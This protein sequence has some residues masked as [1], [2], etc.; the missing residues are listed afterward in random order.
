MLS[1]TKKFALLTTG[2]VGAL[3][4][5]SAVGVA[6]S[7][8][9]T[10]TNN[11][12][13]TDENTKYNTY[14][15]W[16]DPSALD[17]L[18]VDEYGF[19]YSD[20]YKHTI[21]A[22]TPTFTATTITIPST[23]TSITGYTEVLPSGAT[24]TR[25]AFQPTA[26]YTPS[27]SSASGTDTEYGVTLAN[28]ITTVKFAAGSKLNAIG[29]N[30]FNGCSLLQSIDLPSTVTMIGSYAFNGCSLL[31]T[32]NLENV[33]F[34]G[35][36]AF[37]SVGSN[38][39]NPTISVTMNK[40]TVV[41]QY[42]F[43]NSK[44]TSLNLS[45]NTSLISLGN[46]AFQNCSLL[47][48]SLDLS[49][50]SSLTTIGNNTFEGCNALTSVGLPSSVKSIG[51][52]AFQNCTSLESISIPIGS[53]ISKLGN[54][55]FNGCTS[56]TQ[57]GA[58]ASTFTAP[59]NLT[60]ISTNLLSGTSIQTVDISQMTTTTPFA[61]SAL[62][63]MTQLTS[64]KFNSVIT[65]LPASLFNGDTSL[66]SLTLPSTITTLV[67]SS[68]APTSSNDA[69]SKL[70][71]YSPFY[72]SSLQTI[73]MSTITSYLPNTSSDATLS[74]T[75]PSYIFYGLSSL[76]SVTLK[77]GTTKLG[78]YSLYGT[79]S[80]NVIKESSQ[81][82]VT[83]GYTTTSTLTN[84]GDNA[85]ENSG[86]PNFIVNSSST[87]LVDVVSDLPADGN[88]DNYL[89]TAAI[90]QSAFKG[91][92][93]TTV[94]LSQAKF[95]VI[96]ISAFENCLSLSS[97]KL[98]TSSTNNQFAVIIYDSA[99]NNLPALTTIDFGD[100]GR[101]I[102][103]I[104]NNNFT[105]VS[106]L[107][108]INLSKIFEE[109]LE[110]PYGDVNDY[111]QSSDAEY[112]DF[113]NPGTTETN[114]YNNV[115]TGLPSNAT[116]SLPAYMSKISNNNV[117]TTDV[118]DSTTTTK[119]RV[120]LSYPNGI[121]F[122]V[123]SDSSGVNQL[124][125]GVLTNNS[126]MSTVSGSLDLSKNTSLTS[127][128]ISTFFGNADLISLTLS[129][130]NISSSTNLYNITT[131][132]SNYLSLSR[133]STRATTNYNSSVVPFGNN[134][135]LTSINFKDFN[136]TNN[137]GGLGGMNV[138]TWGAVQ[139]IVNSFAYSSSSSSESTHDDTISNLGDWTET[140]NNTSI[141]QT[142]ASFNYTQGNNNNGGSLTIS[143]IYQNSSD[144][145]TSSKTFDF[146]S[147]W[148]TDTTY[149]FIHNGI[150]WT[151]TFNQSNNTITISSTSVNI[152]KGNDSTNSSSKL[153]YFGENS[154]GSFDSSIGIKINMTIS[155]LTVVK[156][157]TK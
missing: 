138:N 131:P 16:S 149:S 112:G 139:T 25:G 9:T 62:A 29:A 36:Y 156:P 104:E 70:P 24:I 146:S 143:N 67:S 114:T 99:F 7:S 53:A 74:T 32:I 129:A 34:V 60:Q 38:L 100:N 79:T 142:A 113:I 45:N 120:E 68:N 155:L 119:Q 51:D 78:N 65:T 41:G 110:S 69:S 21:I 11:N 46:N 4:A 61:P 28:S 135:G 118:V 115:F 12:T 8:C 14:I 43:A 83:M 30:T 35:Q 145:N 141:I 123:S 73:D 151:I 107:Q 39:A 102:Y 80:L 84:I 136:L 122:S 6:L 48:G 134:T 116:V 76:A 96:N 1:K 37:Y 64:V 132:S 63:G 95:G 97:L 57:F 10:T 108:N 124:T 111:I 91:S 82:D 103:A 55:V 59:A 87:S 52:S 75:L 89:L 47:T 26:S 137:V 31:S 90:G 93:V 13:S 71:N 72:G 19:V 42:A 58:T 15:N 105:N 121:L 154:D 152:Y 117:F 94:D 153:V 98:P 106:L 125:D 109:T 85:F 147:T 33:E 66:T 22:V 56:L 50:N 5:S 18:V 157:D 92:K 128:G 17:N 44:I 2:L 101:D 126:I 40:A 20:I 148:P 127:I 27:G 49:K 3:V 81:S 150:T 140:S 144:T 133:S 23:V 88:Y 130:T 77:T 86:I 54:S